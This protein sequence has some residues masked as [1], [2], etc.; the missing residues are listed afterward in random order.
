MVQTNTYLANEQSSLMHG[1]GPW[2]FYFCFIFCLVFSIIIIKFFIL[3]IFVVVDNDFMNDI[4]VV[5]FYMF[6]IL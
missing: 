1:A 2:M 4:F 3:Y 6:I 5:P